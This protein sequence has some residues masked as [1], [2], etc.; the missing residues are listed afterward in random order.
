VECCENWRDVDM[1]T[2]NGDQAFWT[3]WRH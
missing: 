1:T 2:C 3:D